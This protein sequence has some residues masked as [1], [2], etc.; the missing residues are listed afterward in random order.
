MAIKTQEQ[1]IKDVQLAIIE[2]EDKSDA[3]AKMCQIIWDYCESKGWLGCRI[4]GTRL[5]FM[6][7]C[8]EYAEIVELLPKAI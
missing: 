5:M 8:A 1:L 6:D 4:S 7:D 2:A 3:D